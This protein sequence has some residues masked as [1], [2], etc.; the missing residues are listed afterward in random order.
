MG[1]SRSIFHISSSGFI[2]PI[3]HGQ[4]TAGG[5]GLGLAIVKEIMEAHGGTV[6]VTS[7]V[8]KGSVF[9]LRFPALSHQI[10]PETVLA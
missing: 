7:Q 5:T 1:S 2:G 3:G 4:R 6:S 10:V 8:D 9:T